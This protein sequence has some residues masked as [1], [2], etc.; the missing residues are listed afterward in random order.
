MKQYIPDSS[1]YKVIKLYKKEKAEHVIYETNDNKS[2]TRCHKE[3]REVH[4][5]EVCVLTDEGLH[6]EVLITL[7]MMLM[8]E[9]KEQ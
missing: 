6:T 7:F 8:D 9:C 2:G 1:F 3:K 5:H 4:N